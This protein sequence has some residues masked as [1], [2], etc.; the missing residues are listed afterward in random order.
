MP[1]AVRQVVKD[2]Q[3]QVALQDFIIKHQKEEIRLLTIRLFGQKGEKL[4]PEQTQ[5]L[6][7]EASVSSGEVAKEA[8]LAEF[9]E[10][11]AAP[12]AKRVRSTNPGRSRPA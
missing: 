12:K 1:E 9:K 11:A 2:L 8:D 4:S 5:L 3:A 7:E 10:S 6:L